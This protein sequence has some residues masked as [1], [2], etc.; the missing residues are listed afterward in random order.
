MPADSVAFVVAAVAMFV[1]FMAVLGGVAFWSNLPE[2]GTS[3]ARRPTS[4][5]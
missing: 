4:G 5:H 3:S 1:T 2:R